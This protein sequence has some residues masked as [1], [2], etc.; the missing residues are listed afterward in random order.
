MDD[1][2]PLERSASTLTVSMISCV[3]NIF[4]D[5]PEAYHPPDV[6][7]DTRRF[8]QPA[9]QTH[10]RPT[11]KPAA[12]DLVE[13]LWSASHELIEADVA[14]LDRGGRA[15][16]PIC[17]VDISAGDSLLFLPCDDAHPAHW[18]CI[19]QWLE[20]A[21]SCPVCRFELPTEGGGATHDPMVDKSLAAVERLKKSR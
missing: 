5:D 12:R 21:N 3:R 17:L 2:H 1:P 18:Q 4:F 20:S 13:R 6:A 15:C 19:S 10:G 16:C 8:P 7:R 9:A 11:R 14:V